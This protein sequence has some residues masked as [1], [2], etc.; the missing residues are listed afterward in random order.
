MIWNSILLMTVIDVSIIIST[1]FAVWQVKRNFPILKSLQATKPVIFMLSGLIV[2]ALFYTADLATMLVLPFFMPMKKAM[3]IMNDLHLNL[4]WIVS[5][6]GVGLI[7]G[8]FLYLIK[9]LFPRIQGLMNE[10]EMRHAQQRI[11][12]SVV[13]ETSRSCDDYGCKR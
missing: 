1:F 5:L 2:I 9:N 13:K 6:V 10:I 11:Y 12:Y 8:G 3:A 7:I 4:K